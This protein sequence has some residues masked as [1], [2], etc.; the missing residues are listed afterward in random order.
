MIY[1]KNVPNWERGLRIVM[2]VALLALAF[3]GPWNQQGIVTAALTGS[4]VSIAIT[5]FF[6]WC[7]ACAMI[8]RKIERNEMRNS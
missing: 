7:P 8:G 4:A 1:R 2:A 6:G 5:G 3:T